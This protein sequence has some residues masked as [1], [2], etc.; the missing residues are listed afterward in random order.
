MKEVSHKQY[1]CTIYMKSRANKTSLW[2]HK[3]EY[4]CLLGVGKQGDR[5]EREIWDFRVT[6]MLYI[7]IRVLVQNSSNCIFKI[8]ALYCV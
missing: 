5:L 2:K 4:L 8:C 7:W 3:L 1:L 6:A